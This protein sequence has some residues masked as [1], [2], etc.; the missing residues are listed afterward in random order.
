MT[1]NIPIKYINS[2]G[3]TDFQVLVFTK[4]FSLNTPE[5]YFAAWQVLRAQN[6]AEF[7]YPVEIEVGASYEHGGQ[8]IT[9]GPFGASLGSTWNISQTSPSETSVLSESEFNSGGMS[10]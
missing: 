2:T 7:Q 6:Q 9:S 10:P 3:S 5:T 1:T 8:V 4:N